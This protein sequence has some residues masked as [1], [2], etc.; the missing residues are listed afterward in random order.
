MEVLLYAICFDWFLT[1]TLPLMTLS[2]AGVMLLL[3]LF[4]RWT[5]LYT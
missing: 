2:V 5:M 1:P 4:E 3:P